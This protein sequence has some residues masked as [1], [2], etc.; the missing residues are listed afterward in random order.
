MLK[1]VIVQKD[2][3]T[4][5][6]SQHIPEMDEEPTKQI[7]HSYDINTKYLSYQQKEPDQILVSQIAF[8]RRKDSSLLDLFESPMFDI[9]MIFKYLHTQSK[10]NVI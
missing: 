3:D 2:E 9:Y 10:P 1:S 6:V 8:D 5:I 4:L 7:N